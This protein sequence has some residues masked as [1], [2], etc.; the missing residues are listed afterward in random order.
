[1]T[2]EE[3]AIALIRKGEKLALSM[4]PEG[5]FVGF[6]GGKDSQVLL[7]LVKRAGVKYKAYYN[8]TTNDPP[9][10][11]RFIREHYPEVIFLH[12]KENFFKMVEK[13]GLPTMLRRFC[14]GELKEKGGIGSVCLMGVRREESVKRAKYND[15]AIISRR[16]EHQDRNKK[17]TIEE[18]EKHEHKCIKGKDKLVIRPI[19]DWT[20]EEIWQFIDDNNLP[21]NPCYNE[22][23][24]VG[25][26]FC[27]FSSKK[28]IEK[29]ERQYP[30]MKETILK[31]LQKFIDKKGDNNFANAEERYDWWKSKESVK[32]YKAKQKQLRLN[33]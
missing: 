16:K 8:V 14:C 4:N 6:S 33:L 9:T 11:V 25:C 28:Q 30:K 13:K 19:L 22:S 17:R 1:M 26:M 18:I 27:P 10:N 31:A 32:V 7:E 2:K 3:E 20:T 15:V 12:P 24:R 21:N 29:Y 23:G 5:Y